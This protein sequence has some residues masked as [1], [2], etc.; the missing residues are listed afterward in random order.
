MNKTLVVI[1]CTL[2]VLQEIALFSLSSWKKAFA[3]FTEVGFVQGVIGLFVSLFGT[4]LDLLI[5]PMTWLGG[6]CLVIT[7]RR[8]SRKKKC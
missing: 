7:W 6:I 8:S 5:A 3:L 2:I 4:A 1:G